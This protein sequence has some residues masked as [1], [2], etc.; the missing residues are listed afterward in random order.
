LC[1]ANNL[2]GTPNLQSGTNIHITPTL[3]YVQSKQREISETSQWDENSDSELGV[4]LRWAM[5]E[6]WI[7]N[8][9]LNPD[10][11]QVEADAGQLDINSTFSLYYPE[12]RPFLD[13]ADYFSTVNGLVYTRNIADPDFGIEVTGKQTGSSSGV[14][15]TRD[16]KTS[17]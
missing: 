7:L 5:T 3:T 16:T 12:A 11:S 9:T 13:R 17:F 15:I 1:I 4:D 2:I 6:R 14:I 10:F 8:A